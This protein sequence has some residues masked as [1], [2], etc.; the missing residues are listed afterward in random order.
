[1]SDSKGKA[2][3]QT[4]LNTAKAWS[5]GEKSMYWIKPI[6]RRKYKKYGW[7][8]WVAVKVLWWVVPMKWVYWVLESKKVSGFCLSPADISWKWKQIAVTFHLK[9]CRRWSKAMKTWNHSMKKYRRM[10]VGERLQHWLDTMRNTE[11][12]RWNGWIITY[13]PHMC[14]NIHGFLLV[15]IWWDQNKTQRVQCC[16]VPNTRCTKM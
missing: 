12:I 11:K 8:T 5:E 13:G 6:R 1:M 14:G 15:L 9:T 4:F 3:Q 10:K 16:S 7:R 2:W